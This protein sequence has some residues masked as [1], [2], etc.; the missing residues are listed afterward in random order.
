M[1]GRAV[2]GILMAGGLAGA[3][4]SPASAAGQGYGYV[5]VTKHNAKIGSAYKAKVA[6]NSAGGAPTVIR[7]GQGAYTVRFPK[8]GLKGGVAHVTAYGGTANSCSVRDWAPKSGGRLDVRVYCVDTVGQKVNN[9]FSLAY[10]NIATRA[11]SYAYVVSDKPSATNFT[12]PADKQF[13]SAGGTNTIIHYAT[14]AYVV[15]IP[16][17][18][19]GTQIR[20]VHSQ[21]TAYGNSQARCGIAGWFFFSK[22]DDVGVTVY[23]RSINGDPQNTRFAF[24]YT[25]RSGLQ[26]RAP[27]AYVYAASSTL[28][29]P[30]DPY[31]SYD[32]TGGALI[33]QRQSTGRYRID[34]PRQNLDGGNVQIS[35]YGTA[36]SYCGVVHW[37]SKDGVSV[38]C[39]DLNGNPID[40]AF[41]ASFQR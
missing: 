9:G 6:K 41:L 17:A 32:S 35:A 30:Y 40:A 29:T 4:A 8:L 10:T 24:S 33:V 22:T 19:S 1:S 28:T 2:L 34:M 7:T 20:Y 3:L 15:R 14:G 26:R 16:R 18:R 13:N 23:C 37:G 31:Y 12:P 36:D 39:H 38:K 27:A 11:G 25:S 21:V 5:L